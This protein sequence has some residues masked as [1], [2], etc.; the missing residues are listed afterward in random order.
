MREEHIPPEPWI[1]RQVADEEIG[2]C[3]AAFD[4]L[5]LSGSGWKKASTVCQNG[6]AVAA[7]T[8]D[9][10]LESGGTPVSW[11][12]SAVAAAGWPARGVGVS[13]D[14]KTVTYTLPL[15]RERTIWRA[16]TQPL[17][18]AVAT[19]QIIRQMDERLI[20]ATADKPVGKY[21]IVSKIRL[22]TAGRPTAAISALAGVPGLVLDQMQQTASGYDF[23]ISV[24]EVGVRPKNVKIIIDAITDNLRPALGD[25]FGDFY[26]Q[27]KKSGDF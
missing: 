27:H 23:T 2:D 6:V 3:L 8:H 5:P 7:Y 19:S 25:D 16:G 22:H 20:T 26:A 21:Y 14:A 24:A 13:A 18:V 4:R 10:P 17:P 9:K 1:N 12:R 11:F 15:P